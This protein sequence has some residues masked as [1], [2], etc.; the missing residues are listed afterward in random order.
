M[1]SQ[2]TLKKLPLK[3]APVSSILNPSLSNQ[4]LSHFCSSFQQ[5][6]LYELSMYTVSS[7]SFPIFF[8]LNL[9]CTDFHC[10]PSSQAYVVRDIHPL[11]NFQSSSSLTSWNHLKELI[12]LFPLKHLPL[13]FYTLW[14]PRFCLQ[15]SSLR[16]T[17]DSHDPTSYSTSPTGRQ[18]TLQNWYKRNQTINL[19]PNLLHPGLSLVHKWQFTFPVAN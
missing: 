2:P 14:T 1:T 15:P 13:H 8:S 9:F 19:F 11:V 16:K 5:N 7:S 17:L 6:P 12:I 4:P 3:Q 18:W 10:Y